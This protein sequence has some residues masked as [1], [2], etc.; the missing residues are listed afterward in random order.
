MAERGFVEEGVWVSLDAARF[1]A[2]RPALLLD[3]DGVL[4]EEVG[5]LRRPE[6]VRLAAGA[7]D[8]LKMARTNGVPSIVLSNQSGLARGLMDWDDYFD[9]EA[10]I[11]RQLAQSGCSLDAT[12]VAPFHPG[13]TPGY[14]E[15]HA[16][17]RKPGAAMYVLAAEKLNLDLASSWAIGDKDSDMEAAR[18]GGLAGAIHLLT[19]HGGEHRAR[20]L[21][22][23]TPE[24][25]VLP[26]DDLVEAM[27]LLKKSFPALSGGTWGA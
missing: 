2:A 9:V 24:F 19:G 11:A 22:V 14:S 7:V 4:V 13:Y 23:A 27:S 26:A 10:E 17:W 6:D 16:N 21:K 1:S 25:P 5:Y 18:Q 8:I 15:R 12:F 3:R 20:A